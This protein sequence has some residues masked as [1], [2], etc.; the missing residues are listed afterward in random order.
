MQ[1]FVLR[2]L[3]RCAQNTYIGIFQVQFLILIFQNVIWV[4]NLF[5][6]CHCL[7]EKS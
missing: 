1:V 2:Y 5:F 7:E 3:V 6:D 4:A